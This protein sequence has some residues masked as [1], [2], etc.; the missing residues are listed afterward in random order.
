MKIIIIKEN[1]KLNNYVHNDPARISSDIFF[2]SY[3]T[4]SDLNYRCYFENICDGYM[5]I[6]SHKK[7][8]NSKLKSL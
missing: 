3:T 1:V 5:F 4:I 6:L 7:L 2:D 8:K